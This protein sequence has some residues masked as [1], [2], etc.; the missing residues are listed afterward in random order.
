VI[1]SEETSVD[2]DCFIHYTI[3]GLATFRHDEG[4]LRRENDFVLWIKIKMQFCSLML[5][6]NPLK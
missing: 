4:K 2:I 5:R 1:T 6:D 3:Y